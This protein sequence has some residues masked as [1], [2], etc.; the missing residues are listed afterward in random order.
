LAERGAGTKYAKKYVIAPVERIRLE[1]IPKAADYCAMMRA[2]KA[3]T[4][5]QY[6]ACLKKWIRNLLRG[7][8][9]PAPE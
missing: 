7:I 1:I 5:P 4:G 9:P 8:E 3:W 6:R 2:L